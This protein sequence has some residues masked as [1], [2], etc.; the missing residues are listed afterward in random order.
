NTASQILLFLPH[1]RGS[2]EVHP[3]GDIREVLDDFASL[4]DLPVDY[5]GGGFDK[6]AEWPGAGHKPGR[7][8]VV[9]EFRWIRSFHECGTTRVDASV[10]SSA[11]HGNVDSLWIA[12]N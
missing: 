12:P 5:H 3:A 6:V 11:R 2:C 8:Y 7:I 10:M 1:A 4:D 9:R